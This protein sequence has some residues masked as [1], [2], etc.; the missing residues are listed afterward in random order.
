M[1]I[2][3]PNN[4]NSAKL[5][6]DFLPYFIFI[7]YP[8]PFYLTQKGPRFA[9]GFLRKEFRNL[10]LEKE[11]TSSSQRTTTSREIP[12]SSHVAILSCALL[13]RQASRFFA[14]TE[15]WS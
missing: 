9:Q 2:C 15:A 6:I 13:S 10:S 7:A 1:Y 3:F 8:Q 14:P 11:N 5:Y 4:E 12:R